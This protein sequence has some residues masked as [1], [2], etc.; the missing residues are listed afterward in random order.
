MTEF[1]SHLFDTSDFPS[2]WTCGNWTDPHGWLHIGADFAIFAAY[3]AIPLTIAFFVA[4]RPDI[5]YPRLYWLFAAFIFSCGFVHLLEAIIFWHPWYRFSGLAKAVTAVVSWVAVLALIRVLPQALHLPGIAKL[6]AQLLAEIEERKAAE[7]EVHRLNADLRN[8]V[9]ELE[10]LLNVIPVGIAITNDPNAA[11]IR[12][13]A[14][15]ARMLKLREQAADTSL[16]N[17][18]EARSTHFRILHN[19]QELPAAELPIQRAASTGQEIRDFE[20]EVV[21]DSGEHLFLLGYASPLWSPEKS[22]RGAVG[23]FVDITARKTAEDERRFLEAKLQENQRLESV[24]MLAGGIAHDF[25]NLLTSILGNASLTRL[26]L[27]EKSP[28]LENVEKIE[29]ESMRAADLCKQMLAYAGKGQ[30]ELRQL[31]VNQLI[32]NATE[33]LKST[34]AKNAELRLNLQSP[35]PSVEGDPNQ[36]KQIVLNL[37]MNG[38]DALE[39]RGGQITITTG[40]ISVSSEDDHNSALA[41]PL[42]AGAYV[43]LE[44]C[45]NGCGMTPETVARIF[46]P[47]YSTKFIGRGLGLAAVQGIVRSHKGGLRLQSEPGHGTTLTVLLPVSGPSMDYKLVTPDDTDEWQGSG[48]LLVIDDEPAVR[49]IT[50]QL[51]KIMGFTPLIAA[52][53]AEGLELFQ[54]HRTTVVG[55]LLDLTMPSMGGQETLRRLRLLDPNVNVLLMSGYTEEEVRSRFDGAAIPAFIH[56]PFGMTELR[57]KLQQLT[58]AD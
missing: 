21:F 6:N 51:L 31:D 58:V 7:N 20:E 44:V 28:L 49:L 23:A 33:L 18:W 1:F 34:I 40:Q 9:E 45:D 19:R 36:L 53:G 47:F 15:L 42:E 48:E 4:R 27:P 39:G 5:S 26:Q 30:F 46:E 54:K 12:T 35:L 3:A 57:Q 14:M 50:A 41:E 2:R 38:S 25:N 8:R 52:S 37:V 10:T 29:S 43:F 56:K 16:S 24:G 55:V 13:N 22:V 17:E 11:H 32:Q